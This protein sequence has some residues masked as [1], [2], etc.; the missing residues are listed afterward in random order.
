[1]QTKTPL[2][3]ETVDEESRGDTCETNTSLVP[4][5]DRDLGGVENVF[6]EDDTVGA[7][8]S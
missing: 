2:E 3:S 7:S 6:A 1:L 8:P 4:A 5:V